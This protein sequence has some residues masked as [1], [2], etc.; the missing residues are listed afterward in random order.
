MVDMMQEVTPA[1]ESWSVIHP[2]EESGP[3]RVL[4]VGLG[5]GA[6]PAYMLSQCPKGSV[7]VES[8]EYD[9]RVV[10]AAERF[11][12]FQVIPGANE[13]ETDDGGKAVARRASN[14]DSSSREQYDV[15]LVDCF[16]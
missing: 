15:V 11:F 10:K 4:L 7:F 9:P 1:C 14:P 13:V 8:V 6:L 2:G 16:G 3:M 5:G 12:G